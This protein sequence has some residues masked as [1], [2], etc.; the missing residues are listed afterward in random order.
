MYESASAIEHLYEHDKNEYT[1]YLS[2]YLADRLLALNLLAVREIIECCPITAIPNMPA[3]VRGAINLRGNVIPVV[4]LAL[5]L[6]YRPTELKK[7]TCIIVVECKMESETL[8]VG[9]LVDSVHQVL[10]IM[11][12]QTEA[13]PSFGGSIKTEFIESMGK[14]NDKFVVILNIK[15]ILSMDDVVNAEHSLFEDI[16]K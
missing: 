7:R 4:D 14:L 5:R 3:F 12:D 13:P 16:D 8:Q 15:E 1:S 11:L 9:L 10:D 6:G 2:F